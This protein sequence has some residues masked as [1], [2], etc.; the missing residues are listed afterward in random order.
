MTM[1]YVCLMSKEMS[2]LFLYF[3]LMISLTRQLNKL[4]MVVHLRKQNVL[5][6]RF[7]H[8]FL[9]TEQNFSLDIG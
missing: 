2:V 5:L 8:C 4:P 3:R 9:F 1:S 6:N 7:S